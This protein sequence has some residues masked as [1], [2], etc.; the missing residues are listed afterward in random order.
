V[1]EE[2]ELI[3]QALRVPPSS[4]SQAH[5][6]QILQWARTQAPLQRL[7]TQGQQISL[8]PLTEAMEVVD[9]PSQAIIFEQGEP[10]DAYYLVFAGEVGMLPKSKHEG[11]K[12]PPPTEEQDAA[13]DG[14][15]NR[16]RFAGKRLAN[17][18]LSVTAVHTEEGDEEEAGEETKP[19]TPVERAVEAYKFPSRKVYA[20]DCVAIAT[21]GGAF[22]EVSLLHGVARSL[23][24][25]ALAGTLLVKIARVAYLKV[26][27]AE[28]EKERAKAKQK[29]IRDALPAG[30]EW[31]PV[32]LRRLAYEF[33]DV[34][35]SK[36]SVLQKQG[37]PPTTVWVVCDGEVRVQVRGDVSGRPVA[38][39]LCERGVLLG[40]LRQDSVRC[41][42][43]LVVMSAKAALVCMSR[44]RFFTQLERQGTIAVEA[45][46]ARQLSVWREHH[47]GFLPIESGAN[48]PEGGTRSARAA[49][50][51]AC[52][53][54][55]SAVEA[56]A[57]EGGRGSRVAT[58]RSTTTPRCGRDRWDPGAANFGI[59]SPRLPVVPGHPVLPQL[60]M[61]SPRPPMQTMVRTR[62]L[63]RS[64]YL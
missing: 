33:Q 1:G 12:V 31:T 41:S 18:R 11:V 5:K 7:E 34:E 62:C 17:K 3:L 29:L 9:Y 39:A 56:L 30:H 58:P 4:R 38:L 16:S 45:S 46:F 37:S 2:E 64:A 6:D 15:K 32:R 19:P 10:G 49:V 35:T 24:V 22:G 44:D 48:T 61:P 55:L 26:A 57:A 42:Y 36:G 59:K 13:A 53:H 23:S 52:G 60:R 50:S 27:D 20:S 28:G 43:S 54:R 47:D 21:K 14:K 51:P 25:V 40:E 63:Q 8:A